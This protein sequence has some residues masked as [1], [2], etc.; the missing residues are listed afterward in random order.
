[1]NAWTMTG[2][3]RAVVARLSRADLGAGGKGNARMIRGIAA[4]DLYHA[5]Q[6]QLLKRLGPR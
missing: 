6:I 1:M 5:G 3:G 4:H 2:T